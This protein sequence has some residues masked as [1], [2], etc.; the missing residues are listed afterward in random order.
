MSPRARHHGVR[1][2]CACGWKRW[3]KCPHAWYFNFK[4]KAGPHHRFSLDAELGHHLESKTDA[5]HE[6]T[7][8]RAAILAGTF[9]RA[10]GGPPQP[11]PASTTLDDL[12]RSYLLAVKGTGK[13][14]V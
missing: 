8:I 5:E 12:A 9:R 1:K 13:R 11:A 4:P 2:V 3:P 7:R 14:S 10:G 6:A